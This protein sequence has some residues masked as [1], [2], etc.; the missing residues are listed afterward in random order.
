[1]TGK[2]LFAAG[3][4]LA[5]CSRGPDG[6]SRTATIAPQPNPSPTG[7]IPANLQGRWAIGPADCDPTH[8]EPRG[9]LTIGPAAFAFGA[10]PQIVDRVILLPGRVAFDTTE[11]VEGV[12][13]SRRYAFRRSVDGRQLTRERTG[14]VDQV[15]TRCAN[16]PS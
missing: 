10:T 1:M 3:L 12:A 14:L 13:E 16:P 15:Y 11:T 7:A 9:L 8:G 2:I 5:G 4:A 6:A